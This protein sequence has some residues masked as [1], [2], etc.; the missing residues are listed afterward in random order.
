M[1]LDPTHGGGRD[2]GRG[3]LISGIVFIVL[4]LL[5]LALPVIATLAVELLIAWLLL[6]WGAG[7]VAMAWSMRDASG[8]VAMT[9]FFLMILALGLIFLFV[10]RVG[11]STLT[12]VL[13]A[14]FL[15]EGGLTIGL[16][17]RLREVSGRWAWIVASGVAALL[18]GVLILTG[19]PGT[20][21]WVIGLIVGVNFLTTGLSLVMLS[22]AMGHGG[23]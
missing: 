4:G 5:A 8:R 1:G 15:L 21:A 7:G 17:L 10:P 9:A 23:D 18:L 13:A 11:L 16:G 19:W 3:I 22:L 12:L 2:P 20:A 6:F 14:I